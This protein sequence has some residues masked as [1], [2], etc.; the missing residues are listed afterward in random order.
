MRKLIKK[1]LFV[2]VVAITLGSYSFV[3]WNLWQSTK[4]WP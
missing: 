1:L 3:G 4:L 2:G